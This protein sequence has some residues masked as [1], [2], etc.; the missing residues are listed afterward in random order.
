MPE[1]SEPNEYREEEGGQ[2][3]RPENELEDVISEVDDVDML[4]ENFSIENNPGAQELINQPVV[5]E[6]ALTDK[7]IIEM[8]NY[9]FRDDD[10]EPDDD[11]DNE[12][13]LPSP[14]NIT[15]AT[16]ALEKVIKF[17]KSLEVGKGFDKKELKV[18]RK[19][20]KEWRYEREKN[21]K[22]L[23]ISSFLGLNN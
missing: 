9:E 3:S 15:E 12:P 1:T 4:A 17:Q 11:D 10:D 16:E 6:D 2:E 19:K 23:P 21:K 8:V 5:T 13:S 20:F 14:I 7:G 22:Q 18:L